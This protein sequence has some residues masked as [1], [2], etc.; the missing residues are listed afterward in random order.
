[1]EPSYST[2]SEDSVHSNMPF[3]YNIPLTPDFELMSQ[4]TSSP[5]YTP[6]YTSSFSSSFDSPSFNSCDFTPPIAY[7]AQNMHNNSQNATT[8][9]SPMQSH[10]VWPPTTAMAATAS[11]PPVDE[12]MIPD[13]DMDMDLELEHPYLVEA[14]STKPIN[15]NMNMKPFPCEDCSAAF[16]RPADLKRHQSSVHN[17]VFQDC[18]VQECLRKAGNGFP[19][20]DH[21]IEHLRSYHHWD[22]PKRRAA[23]RG[24]ASVA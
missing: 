3:Y 13:L 8:C 14:E 6:S 15:M 20:R 21:L 2:S 9:F 17:P 1:M 18:P 5:T 4:S 24:K 12:V 11:M 16:T 22:L 23:K 10:Y 19:R 7:P